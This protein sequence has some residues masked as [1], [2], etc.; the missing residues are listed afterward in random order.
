MGVLPR[1]LDGSNAS[2]MSL[3]WSCTEPNWI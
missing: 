2:R 3:R 1:L